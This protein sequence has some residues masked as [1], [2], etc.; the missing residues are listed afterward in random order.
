MHLISRTFT[1]DTVVKNTMAVITLGK[2]LPSK[3]PPMNVKRKAME[4]VC[5]NLSLLNKVTLESIHL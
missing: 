1:Q 5:T 2:R 3:Y 4:K